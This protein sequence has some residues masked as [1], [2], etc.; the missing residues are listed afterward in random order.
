MLYNT[1]L[2]IVLSHH[3]VILLTHVREYVPLY[4]YNNIYIRKI[5]IVIEIKNTKSRETHG[6]QTILNKC[7]TYNT[8]T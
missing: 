2:N 3:W 7:H 4:E 6:A 5:Q 1:I 8:N